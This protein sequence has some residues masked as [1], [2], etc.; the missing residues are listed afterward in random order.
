MQHIFKTVSMEQKSSGQFLNTLNYLGVIS[1]CQKVVITKWAQ[2]TTIEIHQ[3][4]M[5]WK[6]MRELRGLGNS[7]LLDLRKIVEMMATS[8]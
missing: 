1:K 5:K 3:T 7:R 8:K 6:M 2:K 4:K